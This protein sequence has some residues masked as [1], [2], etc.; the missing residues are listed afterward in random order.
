MVGPRSC[1]SILLY[2]SIYVQ[3]RWCRS[4]WGVLDLVA[5]GSLFYITGRPSSVCVRCV[6]CPLRGCEPQLRA[7]RDAE[8]RRAV[9]SR[10]AR[11]TAHRQPRRRA[12]LGRDAALGGAPRAALRRARAL[13]QRERRRPAGRHLALRGGHNGVRYRALAQQ[14]SPDCQGKLTYASAGTSSST[15]RRLSAPSPS[16]A[17]A[18]QAA[19]RR[20]HVLAPPSI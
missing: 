13:R 15:C 11:P 12:H 10:L 6:L 8:H 1:S 19:H 18:A 20:R 5:L 2:G 7:A 17:C 9:R 3:Y 16:W 14:T 4:R